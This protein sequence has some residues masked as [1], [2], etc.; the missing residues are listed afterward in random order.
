MP[1]AA[2]LDRLIGVATVAV[3]EPGTIPT[4]TAYVVGLGLFVWYQHRRIKRS[5][6]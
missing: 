6:L 1:L 2:I 4:L 5:K 3:P